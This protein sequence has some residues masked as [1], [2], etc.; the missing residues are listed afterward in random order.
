MSA[1]KHLNTLS[2]KMAPKQEDWAPTRPK[3]P[4]PRSFDQKVADDLRD[5]DEAD[6]REKAK[7]AQWQKEADDKE[8][9]RQARI[10][11]VG[12]TWTDRRTRCV[13]SFGILSNAVK[14]RKNNWWNA[15]IDMSDA[16]E[17]AWNA[18]K[19]DLSAAAAHSQAMWNIAFIALGA[20]TMGGLAV[21][22]AKGGGH[23]LGHWAVDEGKELWI[24]AST[25][26]IQSAVGGLM[27][28]AQGKL[29]TEYSPRP[30]PSP[31]NAKGELEK[32]LN[33]MESDMLGWCNDQQ[34]T[35]RDMPL[36]DF[37]TYDP[38][39]LDK[40]ITKF[41]EEKDRKYNSLPFR[42]QSDKMQMAK[43]I[44]KSMWAQWAKKRFTD[45]LARD[46]GIILD[47]RFS[48]ANSI[49]DKLVSYGFVDDSTHFS[50]AD[51]MKNGAWGKPAAAGMRRAL[52]VIDAYQPKMFG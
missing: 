31:M 37:E 36:E 42:L 4:P 38:E 49:V 40:E 5:M 6:K 41:L 3:G 43:E 51:V 30:I 24:S 27:N 23:F 2:L 21:L 29:A 10:Q 18:F 9:A 26:T 32:L 15:S 13:A 47:T 34:A 52:A 12:V 50:D 46:H 20:C 22:V 25:D 35:V 8:K 48:I 45:E 11:Q 19:D 33:D 39:K 1:T 28:I 7:L 16:Y 14:I 44:E 17:T